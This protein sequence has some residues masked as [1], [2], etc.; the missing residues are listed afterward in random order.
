MKSEFTI[1]LSVLHKKAHFAIIIDVLNE[2]LY[3]NISIY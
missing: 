1:S 3:I 2:L